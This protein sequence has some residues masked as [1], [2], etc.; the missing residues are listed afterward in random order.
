[1]FVFMFYQTKFISTCLLKSLQSAAENQTFYLTSYPLCKS[2][3]QPHTNHALILFV[4]SIARTNLEL[5]LVTKGGAFITGSS[6]SALSKP[7]SSSLPLLHVLTINIKITLLNVKLLDCDCGIWIMAFSHAPSSRP[8]L[9]LSWILYLSSLP[10]CNSVL[11]R[12]LKL[13]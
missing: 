11:L 4:S 1:M 5:D 2:L 10:K 6:A 8:P 13:W 12:S 9:H 7:M 3:H